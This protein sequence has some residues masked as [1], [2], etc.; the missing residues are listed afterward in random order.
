MSNNDYIV[1]GFNK[2]LPPM[3]GY[4]TRALKEH[5]GDSWWN[6]AVLNKMTDKNK[7]DLPESGEESYLVGKLD[8]QRIFILLDA[9]WND[10][11]AQRVNM[12]PPEL[13]WDCRTWSKELL[14]VRNRSAHIGLNDFSNSETARALETMSL[15]C[16]SFSPETSKELNDMSEEVRW[17]GRAP[18]TDHTLQE[19][20]E[21]KKE[22]LS[23]TYPLPRVNINTSDRSGSV[24]IDS[25]RLTD[26]FD[27]CIVR[28]NLTKKIKEGANVPI[29]VLEYLLGMYCSSDDE[30]E[31]QEGLEIVKD[32]LSR[33]YIRPDESELVKSKIREA[34]D[35]YSIIDKVSVSLN[36]KKD[37]YEASFLS[38]GLKDV[39][40]AR[41]MVVDN[42]RLLSGG[43]WCIITFDY[44]YIGDE[45]TLNPFKITRLTPI[46]MP[47]V[48][49][50]DYVSC[51]SN[52]TKDEWIA[53][54]LRSV[55]IEPNNIDRR[56]R[57]LLMGR[58]MALVENNINI[59]EL[60][61]RSTGK[62]HIF[63]EISPSSILV[64]GGQATVASLFYN[65]S[66]HT[67]GLVCN[68]DVVAFDEVA[69]I[70][71]KDKD[72]IAIMKD[73]MASG[74]FSRGEEHLEGKASM[75][76]VGNVKE[77]TRNN[78]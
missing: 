75:V 60:G 34:G 59:C 53:L 66:T 43:I 29:F 33:L 54:M 8:I 3:S 14:G 61:P 67:P 52:F 6:E 22:N 47:F 68:W 45:K 56:T 50:N 38:L 76:F 48:D 69:E 78:F 40:I 65:L 46:Q 12:N 41:D 4:V 10:V 35:G 58:M 28:K 42:S 23:D 21:S 18:S 5:F 9:N 55:G 71:F 32:K 64:S 13:E 74:S 57:M 1:K 26:C 20:V 2:L 72:A 24:T 27:G 62:S 77:F 17:M 16:R 31:I 30:D 36:Y 11:F 25:S 15:L 70:K 39:P 73:Y 51:R 44:S 63:K 37:Y 7:R 49:E 19:T